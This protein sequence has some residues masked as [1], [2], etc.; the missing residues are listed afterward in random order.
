MIPFA[1]YTALLLMSY[2]NLKIAPSR[3]RSQPRSNKWFLGP[4]WVSPQMEF[5]SVQPY[6]AQLTC[7]QH[8]QTDRPR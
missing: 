1:T 5:W 6:F 4:T 7:A 8:T 3:G 2:T